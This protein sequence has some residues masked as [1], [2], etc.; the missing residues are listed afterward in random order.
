MMSV[1]D[2]VMVV[3]SVVVAS[4]RIIGFRAPAFQAL[5]HL[6]VGGLFGAWLISRRSIWFYLSMCLTVVEVA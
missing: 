5:A 4:G 6:F 1:I 3:A 2:L